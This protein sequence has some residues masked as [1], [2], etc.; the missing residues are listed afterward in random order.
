M[1][2]GQRLL[3]QGQVVAAEQP[4]EELRAGTAPVPLNPAYLT[5]TP[6][7]RQGSIMHATAQ[8]GLERTA[9]HRWR[10]SVSLR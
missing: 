3:S 4:L 6:W 8:T 2:Q 7:Q 5:N 9:S 10:E 1:T